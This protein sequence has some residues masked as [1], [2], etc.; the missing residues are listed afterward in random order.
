QEEEGKGQGL[1]A[2]VRGGQS[3]ISGSGRGLPLRQLLKHQ[4]DALQ[5]LAGQ[6]PQLLCSGMLHQQRLALHLA[7]Q[8]AEA[9]QQLQAAGGL[10]QGLG[11]PGG[12][13][14]PRPGG[15]AGATPGGGAGAESAGP[16]SD[17]KS[18][19]QCE[20]VALALQS[21]PADSPLLAPLTQSQ[22]LLSW[23]QGLHHLVPPGGA[24]AQGLVVLQAR[25]GRLAGPVSS[26]PGGQ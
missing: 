26:A 17:W 19:V 8:L 11:A 21:W 20:D 25:I 5:Q 7:Q 1:V 16:G 18:E 3:H 24:A 15:G 12:L 22:A 2:G 9:L 10:L 13:G 6:S 14:E 23:H 4:L